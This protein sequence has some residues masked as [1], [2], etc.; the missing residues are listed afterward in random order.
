MKE[1]NPHTYFVWGFL[2][3]IVFLHSIETVAIHL[4]IFKRSLLREKK[5]YFPNGNDI[6]GKTIYWRNFFSFM[7]NTFL[8]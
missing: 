2:Y 4:K 1:Q 5:F 8:K 7:K 6:L 3:K